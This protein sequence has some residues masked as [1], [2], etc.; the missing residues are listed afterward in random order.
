MKVLLLHA[1]PLDKSMWTPQR[2]ALA[3]H[4]AVLPLLGSD[5]ATHREFSIGF[6]RREESGAE[7]GGREDGF[8][9]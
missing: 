9:Y 6:G 5:N 2:T 8:A 3:G 1:F 7:T 4:E